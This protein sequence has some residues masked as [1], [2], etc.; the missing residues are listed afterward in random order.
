MYKDCSSNGSFVEKSTA[1]RYKAHVDEKECGYGSHLGNGDIV[2]IDERS[3]SILMVGTDSRI[4][5][6]TAKV[7]NGDLLKHLDNDG[8]ILIGRAP[9]TTT[10]LI[11]DVDKHKKMHLLKIPGSDAAVSKTQGYFFKNQKGQICY[12]DVSTNGT[13]I[14][15][16]NAFE[17]WKMQN[18]VGGRN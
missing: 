18:V 10:N 6:D 7:L 5:F 9:S 11:P 13:F 17:S 3:P 15:P 14:R 2:A 4:P 12:R 1:L 16:N 8:I